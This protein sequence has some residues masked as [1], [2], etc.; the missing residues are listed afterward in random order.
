MVLIYNVTY[1]DLK[2]KGIQ[3]YRTERQI[4]RQFLWTTDCE[5]LL[6]DRMWPAQRD[7]DTPNFGQVRIDR[8]RKMSSRYNFK[9]KEL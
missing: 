4:P 2:D 9:I 3:Q 5:D 7:R 8:K 6:S 1:N